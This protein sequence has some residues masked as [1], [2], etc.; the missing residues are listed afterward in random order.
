VLLRGKWVEVDR[1]GMGRTMEQFYAA[2]QLAARDGLSFSEAMRMLAG[3]AVTRDD[4]AA[5]DT[6]WAPRRSHSMRR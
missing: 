4:A 3:A 1:V 2:E 6:D 5:A